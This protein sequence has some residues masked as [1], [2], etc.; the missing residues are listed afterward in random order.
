MVIYAKFIWLN[1]S[2]QIQISGLQTFIISIF[3]TNS[4]CFNITNTYYFDTIVRIFVQNQACIV[5]SYTP[6]IWS[7]F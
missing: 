4:Y 6:H 5:L 2:A 7:Q 1:I 3:N